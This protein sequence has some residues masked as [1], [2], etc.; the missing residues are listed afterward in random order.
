MFKPPSNAAAAAGK[1]ADDEA[2]EEETAER[3][4][5]VRQ[6]GEAGRDFLIALLTSHKLGVVFHDPTAGTSGSNQNHLLQVGF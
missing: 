5:L 6:V 4:E 1:A 2:D 3:A